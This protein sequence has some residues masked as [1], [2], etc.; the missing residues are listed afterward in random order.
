MTNSLEPLDA[1]LELS[2]PQVRVMPPHPLGGTPALSAVQ[3]TD[4]GAMASALGMERSAVTGLVHDIQALA[5]EVAVRSVSRLLERIR[6]SQ[7]ARLNT[8]AQNIKALPSAPAPGLFDGMSPSAATLR[9]NYVSRESVL[10]LVQSL[11]SASHQR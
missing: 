5:A 3:L 11:S 7:E 2:P 4:L 9:L 8:L 6:Q 1:A 10:A